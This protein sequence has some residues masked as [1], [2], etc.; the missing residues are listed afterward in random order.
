MHNLKRISIV[1]IPLLLGACAS[2]PDNLAKSG[3]SRFG[4]NIR[5]ADHYDA[6]AQNLVF[7]LAQYPNLVPLRTMVQINEPT[8]IFDQALQTRLRDAGYGIQQVTND[9]GENYISTE[10]QRVISDRGEES[11]YS[12]TIGNLTAERHYKITPSSVI[13][14]TQLTITGAEPFPVHLN[15]DVFNSITEKSHSDVFNR[16]VFWNNPTRLERAAEEKDFKVLAMNENGDPPFDQVIKENMYEM[17][18]SNFDGFFKQFDDVQKTV[19]VFPNDS[20]FL[21]GQNKTIIKQ[22]VS[23]M[24]KDTDVMSVIGCSHGKTALE[25][26]NS[27]LAIGRANRVK[28][29]LVT[30]GVDYGK[31]LD[32]GCWAP[33]HFDEKMPRRGVVL[34]LKRRKA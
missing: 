31:V 3:S 26:G 18:R 34:I 2:L 32:E 12:L 20:L 25:N 13:P 8:R 16:V 28:E 7:G 14:S 17:M 21:G 4:N 15:D 11:R 29:A 23:L 22:Y 10:I 19:L 6:I 30:Y 27:R 33:R 5:Y 24:N 9:L 1:L